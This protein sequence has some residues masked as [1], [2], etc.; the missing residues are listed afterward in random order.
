MDYLKMTAPCGLDCFNC[1]F[2]LARENQEAA[3]T[4]RMYS[5][6]FEIPVEIMLCEGCREQQGIIKIHKNVSDRGESEP[7]R[8]YACTKEKNIDFCYE[9]PDFPCENLQPYSDRADKVPH[10]LKVF[11]LCLTKKMGLEAWA[12]DQAAEVR[13]TYFHKWWH[14]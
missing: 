10:N 12:K 3:N 14:L 13:E 6:L 8:P 2:Y 7:C 11:N 9:C 4:L 1:H 5:R